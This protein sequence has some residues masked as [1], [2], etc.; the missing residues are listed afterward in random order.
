MSF[1]SA[2]PTVSGPESVLGKFLWMNTWGPSGCSEIWFSEVSSP[3]EIRE[4]LSHSRTMSCHFAGSLLQ[5]IQNVVEVKERIPLMFLMFSSG[6]VYRWER[7]NF[8]EAP[9][10]QPLTFSVKRCAVQ[11]SDRWKLCLNATWLRRPGDGFPF[12]PQLSICCQE[13]ER[14]NF[15]PLPMTTLQMFENPVSSI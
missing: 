15:K 3:K 7:S 4:S 12:R 5:P 10:A 13:R 2:F 6:H 9:G 1:I 14:I 8:R 11:R